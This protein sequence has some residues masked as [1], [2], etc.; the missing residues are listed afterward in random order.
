MPTWEHLV[1]TLAIFAIG[2]ALHFA[3]SWLGEWRPSALLAAVNESVWEHLKIAFW[4]ALLWSLLR[5]RGNTCSDTSYWAARSFGLLTTSFVIIGVFYGY[6]AI[7]GDNLLPVDI[8]TFALAIFAG[9]LVAAR[10]LRWV[11]RARKLRV[12]GLGLL[13]AQ[14]AAFAT[15]T[16]FPPH[17]PLFEDPRNGFYGLKAY[18]ST[19]NR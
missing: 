7:L 18:E 14:I 19:R 4:P 10:A 11:E 9:Q 6:T 8:A 12:S 5:W 1:A 15:L 2:S 16:F 13:I 3:Y 17:L